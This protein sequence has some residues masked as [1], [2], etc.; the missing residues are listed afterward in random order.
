MAFFFVFNPKPFTFRC[1]SAVLF[2]VVLRL[3]SLREAGQLLPA[4]INSTDWRLTYRTEYGLMLK[5]KIPHSLNKMMVNF[6]Q[7]TTMAFFFVSSPKPF[8]F[9]CFSAVLFSVVLH[10]VSL[11]EAGQLLPAQRNSEDERL[12]YRKEY[13]LMLWEKYP[14]PIFLENCCP[15]S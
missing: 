12:T 3:V 10:L 2:S 5:R 15:Q 4:Q 8:T 6:L 1:F 13:G 14:Y 11:W 7:S 9:R